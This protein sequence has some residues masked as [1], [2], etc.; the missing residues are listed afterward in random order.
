M[1]F[2]K[3]KLRKIY[4]DLIGQQYVTS[5]LQE[6]VVIKNK[7]AGGFEIDGLDD[8]VFALRMLTIHY[9]RSNT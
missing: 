3:F 6:K 1:R 5:H 2:V 9:E 8:K 7:C 4:L